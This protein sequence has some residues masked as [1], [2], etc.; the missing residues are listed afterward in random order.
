[1]REED[2][3]DELDRIREEIL[4]DQE[5]SGQVDADVWLASHPEYAEE[6]RSFIRSLGYDP[7][8]P[9]T[10]A[11]DPLWRDV[12]RR[13]LLRDP[14]AIG[15]WAENVGALIAEARAEAQQPSPQLANDPV[16]ASADAFT[17]ALG[18]AKHGTTTVT[19]L[20]IHKVLYFVEEAFKPNLVPT[21]SLGARGPF[22]SD[23]YL[24]EARAKAKGWVVVRGDPQV[25]FGPGASAA[26]ATE[27]LVGRL[28][29]RA[30]EAL[31]DFLSA[32]SQE[33]LE[34]L[35]TVHWAAKEVLA[36]GGTVG[37]P[38]TRAG[39]DKVRAW[40][41]KLKKPAYSDD[42]IRQT[43]VRLTEL[44]LLPRDQVRLE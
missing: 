20:V 38:E 33:D 39:I 27:S 36:G 4:E 14:D 24:G 29:L 11:P 2:M 3:N 40:R 6:I 30:A 9:N 43:L 12:A 35:A 37:V 26:A 19:R 25:D 32:L 16:Q 10:P 5:F 41:Y 8:V 44:Q 18:V 15:A 42:G 22:S 17:W 1:M 21:F 13:H 7:D 28:P 23:L 31:A 34:L